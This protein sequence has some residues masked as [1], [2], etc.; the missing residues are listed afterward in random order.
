[1]AISVRLVRDDL[2]PQ[3]TPDVA[4]LA[5]DAD[6]AHAGAGAAMIEDAVVTLALRARHRADPDLDH[7]RGRDLDRALGGAAGRQRRELLP[8]AHE[9]TRRALGLAPVGALGSLTAHRTRRP[10]A[11]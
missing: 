5:H 7:R 10:R 8:V 6:V 11:P 3:H 4:L 9:R 2:D 1:M